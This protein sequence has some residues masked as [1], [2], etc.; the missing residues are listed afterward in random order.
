VV[1]RVCTPGPDG[2]GPARH[3]RVRTDFADLPGVAIVTGGSGGI[4]A[5]ICRLLAGR[6]SRVALTHHRNRQRADEVVAAITGLGG[7][8]RTWRVSLQDERATAAFVE[9]VGDEFGGV[10]TVVHASGPHVPMTHLSNVTPGEF[11]AQVEQDT[12]GFFNLVHP[13]LPLLRASG[14][15]LVAV[16]TSATRRYAVRDGLSTGPKGAVEA[17]VR[18]LAA[19]EGRFGVRANC[20]GPGMLTD[21]M[22][23]RL[24][25]AGDL[26][27]RALDAARANIPLRRFGTAADVAEAV[28]FLASPQARYISGVMLDVDGGFHV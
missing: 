11:R 16:T 26:D 20:V 12:I 8:A 14:G 15:S 7:T 24:I 23:E 21:G 27:E 6:G 19:E 17:V 10:H 18:A 22:A 4:G 5:A 2:A 3:S 28:A 9:Q 13:A 25:A 1:A